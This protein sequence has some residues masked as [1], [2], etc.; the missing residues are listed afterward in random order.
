MWNDYIWEMYKQ[1]SGNKVIEMFKNNLSGKIQKEY[2][3]EIASLLES[4]VVSK[5][6]KD[7]QRL[8]FIMDVGE[9]EYPNEKAV[10]EKLIKPLLKKLGYSVD[11]YMQQMYIEIGNHNHAL[12]PDFVVNPLQKSDHQSGFAVKYC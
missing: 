5:W 7:I 10:E 11:D 12:I 9:E 4:F 1:T 6:T 8:E 3:D 2:P